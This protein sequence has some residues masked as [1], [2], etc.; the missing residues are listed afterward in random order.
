ML[1]LIPAVKSLTIHEG[2]LNARSVRYSANNLDARIISAL[3]KLPFHQN[4]VLLTISYGECDGEGYELWIDADEIRILAD[5]PAGAF[6]AV[7]TLRQIFKHDVIP[8]LYIKDA[9]DF[10][11]RGFYHDVT[12]GKVPTL[13]SVKELIDLMASYK[14]NSLQLY[15]EHTCEIREYRSLVDQTGY[16]TNDEIR[17][18][19]AYCKEN[20][21]E[22]IPS[23]STFGHLCELLN[24]DEYKHLRVLKD[25]EPRSNFWL[26]RMRHH[27]IDP[28]DPES[29]EVIKSLIDQYSELFSSEYFNICCDETFDLK[30]VSED[31]EVVGKLY[32]EFVEKIIAHV[33][34]RGKKVMMWSDILLKHPETIDK[35]PEDTC[36]LNWFY[37]LDPPEENIERIAQSGR[38]QIVCPGTTTWNRFCECVDVEENNISLMIEYGYKHG[39][40]GVLNTNWGDWGNPCSVEMAMYGLILGA[41]KSWTV[42]TK[43]GERFDACV[44]FHLYENS[45]GVQYLR[46]LSRLHDQINWRLFCQRYFIDRFGNDVE[47]GEAFEGDTKE[48][49]NK[50]VQLLEKVGSEES[51]NSEYRDEMLIA[52]EGICLMVEL[53]S[54]RIGRKVNRV[55]DTEKWLSAYRKKWT[56]KNK[57]SELRNIEEMFR[58]CDKNWSC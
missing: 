42:A 1:K 41:E 53:Y 43:V 3:R 13:E 49:Q 35:L 19:D 8:C 15:V 32:V 46:E 52:I 25:Y 40:V 56:R 22:F 14:L 26:E 39:A 9:P 57:E 21:I 11:H 17:E 20:F 38:P 50:C 27:T 37:R 12:R 54:A 51:F 16:L 55:V 44:N 33:K 7:Q 10:P 31:P 29:I 48:F 5:S 2:N 6:Y 34:S 18:L 28:R 58:Y 45:A 4:G 30:T 36:Y 47:L 24:L 23:L